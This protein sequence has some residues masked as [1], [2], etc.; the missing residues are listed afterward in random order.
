MFGGYEAVAGFVEAGKT[1]VVGHGAVSQAAAA[2][3]SANTAHRPHDQDIISSTNRLSVEVLVL[4][5][6][7]ISFW[8]AQSQVQ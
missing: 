7:T 4:L 6:S 8:N 5:D 1:T 3:A 2:L